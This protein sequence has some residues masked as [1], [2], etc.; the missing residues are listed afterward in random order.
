MGQLVANPHH[1]KQVVYDYGDKL[2][3]I[4]RERLLL[5]DEVMTYRQLLD[6]AYLLMVKCKKMAL[7]SFWCE[8]QG[9]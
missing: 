4:T 1:A 8:Q 7:D 3:R 5:S 6:G 9:K 2:K